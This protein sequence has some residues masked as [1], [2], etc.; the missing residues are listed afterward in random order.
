MNKRITFYI[1]I[2]FLITASGKVYSQF[3]GEIVFIDDSTKTTQKVDDLEQFKNIINNNVTNLQKD[4]YINASADTL[5]EKADSARAYIYKGRQ[6]FWK[7]MRSVNEGSNTFKLPKYKNKKGQPVNLIKLNQYQEKILNIYENNG[8]PFAFLTPKNTIKN[9]SLDLTLYITQGKFY[10]FDSV[11]YNRF[12]ISKSFLSGYLNIK[13][14]EPYNE[15]SFKKIPQKI[16]QLAFLQLKTNPS[17]TFGNG[18]ARTE[19]NLGEKKSNYFNGLVGIIPDPDRDN[20]YLVTGDID[21]TLNNAIGR[22][23]NL[24]LNWKKNDRFSQELDAG[25]KWPYFFRLPLGFDGQIKM[26]KQDTSFVDIESRTG[27]FIFFNGSNTASGYY[28]NKQTIVLNPIDS[29]NIRKTNTYGTGITLAIK[30]QDVYLNP[31][32]GYEFAI[33]ISGGKRNTFDSLNNEIQAGYIDG[34]LKLEGFIPLYKNW[35]LNLRHLYAGIY[36]DKKLYV[37]EYL[38]A[39]GLKTFR[40]FDENE[41]LSTSYNT[42]TIELRWLFENLSHFK[43]FADIGTFKMKPADKTMIKNAIGI[44]TGLNLHTN[45]GIF[46]ISYAIGRYNNTRFQLNNAKIHFGYINSF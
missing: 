37:N 28:K 14:G 10:A 34:K 30:K 4:G 19:L 32:K 22:G 29:I 24:K 18:L 15:S 38:R 27:I 1:F 3:I 46:S 36:S 43:L 11:I 23:E 25:L 2:L 40:G 42:S 12:K 8:Y 20:K 31:S 35:T 45:A 6:I 9:D 5:I 13:P 16:D 21:L 41:F 26:L 7:S 44:G 39:G 17:I 33:D